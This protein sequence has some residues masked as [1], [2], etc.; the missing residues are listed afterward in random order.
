MVVMVMVMVMVAV[1]MVV[2]VDAALRRPVTL[3]SPQRSAIP[4]LQLPPEKQARK[5]TKRTEKQIRTTR[6]TY[7][8][9][10][11]IGPI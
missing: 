8:V 2:V 4:L 5:K 10:A 6:I 1:M 11:G 9:P 3:T 7:H